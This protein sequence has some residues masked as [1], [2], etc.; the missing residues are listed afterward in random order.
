MNFQSRI[1]KFRLRLQNPR[2][3]EASVGYIVIN[4]NHFPLHFP[5]DSSENY[6]F[7]IF[8]LFLPYKKVTKNE[9]SIVEEYN[10]ENNEENEEEN[11]ENAL[12]ILYSGIRI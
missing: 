10:D 5:W 3:F 12:K 8:I 7:S 9:E 2:S 1:L 6:L 11:D 4:F